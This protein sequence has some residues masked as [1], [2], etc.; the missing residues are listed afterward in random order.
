MSSERDLNELGGAE[1]TH[2][3][4]AALG[5]GHPHAG[6]EVE[7]VRLDDRTL[8]MH[9]L[10]IMREADVH[11]HPQLGLR[12]LFL[13]RSAELAHEPVV[14]LHPPRVLHVERGLI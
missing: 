3:H 2:P 8:E 9:H 11:Q 7:D 5:R 4:E 14:L 13:H 10:I 6:D 1:A 12:R